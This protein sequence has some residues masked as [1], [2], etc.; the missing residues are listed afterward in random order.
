MNEPQQHFIVNSHKKLKLM[1]S[2]TALIKKSKPPAT[3][4]ELK[5]NLVA[6]LSEVWDDYGKAKFMEQIK[7]R[8]DKDAIKVL[9]EIY[10]PLIPKETQV[11][12]TKEKVAIRIEIPQDRTRTIT[13]EGGT[14]E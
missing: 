9:K 2:G 7:G 13:V 1:S 14:S 3:G 12:K 4:K 6:A 5:G 10:L 11:E 8:F